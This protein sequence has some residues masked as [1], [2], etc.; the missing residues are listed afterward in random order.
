MLIGNLIKLKGSS[1]N[2]VF[3]ALTVITAIAMYNWI[4]APHVNYLFAVQRYKPVV[5]D[6]IKENK[7]ISVSLKKKQ[8]KLEQLQEQFAQMQGSL[9]TSGQAK[10]FF[11]NLKAVAEKSG[12]TVSSLNFTTSKRGSAAKQ[13]EDTSL[14]YVDSAM[15]SV[16]GTYDDIVRLVEGLQD[17]AQKVLVRSIKMKIHDI[18]LARLKCDVTITMCIMQDEETVLND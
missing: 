15:L 12:C 7:I 9:F 2:A 16:L 8:A 1:R 14:V 5:S 11:T 6:I 3:A 18:N 4:V 10:D 17:R 13:P